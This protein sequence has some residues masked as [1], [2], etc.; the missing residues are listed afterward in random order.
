MNKKYKKEEQC[1]VESKYEEEDSIHED[2]EGMKH[3]ISYNNCHYIVSS[4]AL[5]T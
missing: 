1:S 4:N 2:D 5:I 3:V